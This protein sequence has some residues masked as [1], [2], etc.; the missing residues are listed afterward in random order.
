MMQKL[1]IVTRCLSSGGA[2]RVVSE[3]ANY[4][5]KQNISVTVIMMDENEVF[6]KLDERV[7]LI[8]I[9]EL[10]ENKVLNRIHKYKRARNLV[11]KISPDVVLTMP[12]DIGVYVVQAMIGSGIPVVVSERNN[13]WVMPYNKV[14]RLVR[15]VFYPFAAGYIFQ[16]K[17]AAS[18]FA[19]HIQKRGI[20]LPNPLNSDKI[21]GRYEGNRKKVI[22]AVGRLDRQKNF[23]LLLDTFS[24]FYKTHNNYS[25]VVYGEGPQRAELEQYAA[26]LLEKHSW[27]MPGRNHEWLAE[28][29][30]CSMFVLSS[31]YEGMPN[32]LIEAMAAGIPSISTDCPSGGCRELI[33]N[34]KNGLLIPVGDKTALYN[35]MCRLADD[36]E[37]AEE[38]SKKAVMVK[39][40]LDTQLVCKRWLDYLEGKIRK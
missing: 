33:D 31:D 16:T 35:A 13:P 23:K 24:M 9:G 15:K 18:F 5:V 8:T 4:A 20:V 17:M 39:D 38:I 40:N 29:R 3:I 12:E 10:A 6:Y 25:L 37:F 27:T 34:E 7:R 36:A 14:S 19:R 32:A 2:E 22:V 30:E 1:V 11:K 26:G 28:A 21:P